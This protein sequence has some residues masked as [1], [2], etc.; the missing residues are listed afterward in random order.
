M[1]KITVLRGDGSCWEQKQLGSVGMGALLGVIANLQGPKTSVYN[2]NSC[3]FLFSQ[4]NDSFLCVCV[5]SD[6]HIDMLD[7]PQAKAEMISTDWG[8]RMDLAVLV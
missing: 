4:K 5:I 2:R 7:H 3:K 6:L 1:P 8:T